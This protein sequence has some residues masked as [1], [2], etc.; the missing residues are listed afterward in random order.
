M[1]KATIDPVHFSVTSH[2]VVLPG[3]TFVINVWAHLEEQ[4][5]EVVLRAQEAA[6]G[7]DVSVQSKGPARLGRGTVLLV[8]LQ[9]EDLVIEDQED[10]ILW[11]GSIGNATFSAQVP[12][13]AQKGQRCGLAKVYVSN[14]EIA[15]IHFAVEMGDK[16]SKQGRLRAQ[17]KLH[18]TAFAS[19]A[20]EDRDA[21][22]ARI[23]GIQK[24]APHL[25]VFLDVLKLRSGEDWEKRLWKEIPATD[26]FY[27]FWSEDA[28]HSDWVEKEWRCA[29]KTRGLDVWPDRSI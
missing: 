1:P 28:S 8:R 23:Q 13:T 19:Y 29:L 4:R 3:T 15:K 5:K 14:L 6:D 26:I 17:E 22:L 25:D 16:T 12:S 20:N 21:V 10:T 9:I 7:I 2:S 24:A 11:E 18:R 27:L